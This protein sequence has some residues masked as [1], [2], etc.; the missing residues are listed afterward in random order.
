M[1]DLRSLWF[2]QVIF[3]KAAAFYFLGDKDWEDFMESVFD[4][5]THHSLEATEEAIRK[6]KGQ[7][8][9]FARNA[10]DY[11]EAEEGPGE[12]QA[13]LRLRDLAA[14]RVPH[15]PPPGVCD[16]RGDIYS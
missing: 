4:T 16:C 13:Q 9:A 12:V 15:S 2:I 6:R 3:L 8:K 11:N 14:P 10:A 7:S 1:I 5:A